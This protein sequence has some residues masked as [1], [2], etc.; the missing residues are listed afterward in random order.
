VVDSV[1][2]LDDYRRLD[3]PDRFGKVV[4]AVSEP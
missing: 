4:L 1:F 2:Q 3:H